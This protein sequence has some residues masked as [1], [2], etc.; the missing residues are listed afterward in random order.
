MPTPIL[1]PALSPTMEEGTL[2]KWLVKEGDS[3]ASGD[4]IAEIETDKATMEVEAVDEGTVG[5]LLVAEGTEGVKVNAEIALILEEGEDAGALEA[6]RPQATPAPAK[7]DPA[8]ATQATP[9]PKPEP[10]AAPQPAPAPTPAPAPVQNN[11]QAAMAD[12]RIKA[13]PLARRLAAQAGI[14]LASLSGSGPNG[15]IIKSDVEAATDGKVV[16]APVAQTAAAPATAEVIPLPTP[17]MPQELGIQAGTYDEVKLDGMRKIVAKRMTESK[18]QVPHFPLTVDCEVDKLL[19]MRKELNARAGEG[20]YKIS[21][22]DFV[23]RASALALK[24]QPGLNA[25]FAGDNALMHHHADIAVAVAVE[26]GLFTPIIWK[27]ETKGLQTI[28]EEMKDFAGRARERKLLPEEYQG[29]TFSISNL[30]MFGVKEFAAVINQPHGGILAVGSGEQRPVVK[31]GALAIATVMTC[32]LSVDH[33][34]ADGAVGARWLQV[35]KSYIE[36]PV[37]MLL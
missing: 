36:D 25:S 24:K 33:R 31:D 12:T 8:P 21:V 4:V 29:G 35:F 11:V 10:V 23:I 2:A 9:A 18:Q 17:T 28:S 15:R 26:G 32:T 7:P 30:G 13:S 6:A 14:D 19:A 1:M 3:V 5:K 20:G 22:N 16:A 27:A 34:V 37:T